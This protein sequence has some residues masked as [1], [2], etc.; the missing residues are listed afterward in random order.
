MVEDRVYDVGCLEEV[1]YNERSLQVVVHSVIALL[2]ESFDKF[3]SLLVAVCRWLNAFQVV[4]GCHK[5]LVALLS[6]FQGIVGE[7]N[8]SAVMS[9]ENEETDS[10]RR[11]SLVEGRMVAGEELIQC[12]EVAERLTHFLSVNGYHVVVH[13]VLHHLVAL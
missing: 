7:V 3:V 12:D 10:H 11:V 8:R 9:R 6:G 5:T 13:P 1:A 2:A 4:N